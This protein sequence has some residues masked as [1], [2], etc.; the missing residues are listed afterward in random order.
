MDFIVLVCGGRNF[1]NKEWLFY[2]L[3]SL[4]NKPTL[5]IHGAARGA[6]SLAGVWA[7]SRNVPVKTYPADWDKHGRSAGFIRNKEMIKE[8]PDLVMAFEGGKG[9]AHMIKVARQNDV[10]VSII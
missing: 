8:K 5:I 2:Q 6:D 10:T 4:P 3:D 9:T 1:N 7:K